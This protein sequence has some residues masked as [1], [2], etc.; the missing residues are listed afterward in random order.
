MKDYFVLYFRIAQLGLSEDFSKKIMNDSLQK[1]KYEQQC[2][3]NKK[4]KLLIY[5]EIQI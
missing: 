5:L 4:F 2:Y 1:F 3:N